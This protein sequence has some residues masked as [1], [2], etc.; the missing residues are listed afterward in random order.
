VSVS[1][2]FEVTQGPSRAA[3]GL[4]CKAVGLTVKVKVG[5]GVT[6]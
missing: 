2:Y 1:E 6:L 5:A 3:I 4:D